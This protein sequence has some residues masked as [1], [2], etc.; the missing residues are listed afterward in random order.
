MRLWIRQPRTSWLFALRASG[1]I[2]GENVVNS[3][4]FLFSALRERNS[5]LRNVDDACSYEPRLIVVP[6]IHY[7][8]LPGMQPQPQA[9]QPLRESITH[10]T[11]PDTRSNNAAPRH[12]QSRWNSTDG[13]SRSSHESI[14]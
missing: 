9:F 12:L 5:Y 11:M 2:A 1:L 3:C 7:P 10:L 6:A 4:P 14:A 13:N 8:G